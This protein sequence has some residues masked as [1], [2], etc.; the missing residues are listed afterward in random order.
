MPE[1]PGYV[2]L[3]VIGFALAAAAVDEAKKGAKKV[4]RGVKRLAKKVVGR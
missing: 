4:G 2:W 3:A 1:L